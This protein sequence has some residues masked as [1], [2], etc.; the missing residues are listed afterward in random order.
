MEDE[1]STMNN[2]LADTQ[3]DAVKVL[4]NHRCVARFVAVDLIAPTDTRREL[5]SLMRRFHSVF[6]WT[7]HPDGEVTVEFDRTRISDA[8]IEEALARLGFAVTHMF[9]EQDVD[10]GEIQRVLS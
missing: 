3:S 5:E 4:P 8:V 2:I 6:A 1:V 10:E 9:Y 7:I